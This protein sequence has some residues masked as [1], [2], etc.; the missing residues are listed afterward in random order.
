MGLLVKLG[1]LD[2]V[3]HQLEADVGQL[4]AGFLAGSRGA[5]RL[6]SVSLVL[7]LPPGMPHLLLHL[8]VWIIRTSP[9]AIEDQRADGGD[10]R[11]RGDAAMPVEKIAH[12]AQVAEEQIGIGALQLFQRIVAGQDGAAHHA[13]VPGRLDVVDHVADEDG[14]RGV[15]IV[16]GQQMQDDLALVERLRRRPA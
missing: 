8:W 4:E 14:F 2:A 7:I 1:R 10:G 9:W 15:E 11:M 13:G 6:R 16:L 12:F 3:L 5:G